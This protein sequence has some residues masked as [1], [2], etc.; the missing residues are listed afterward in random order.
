MENIIMKRNLH[1]TNFLF[2]FLFFYQSSV[3][4]LLSEGP[5]HPTFVTEENAGCLACQGSDWID[6]SNAMFPDSLYAS[7]QLNSYANC[8]MNACY[9][10]KS[11]K[12]ENFVFNIPATA[13]IAG[14]KVEVLRKASAANA[15]YDSIVQLLQSA[16]PVGNNK[17]YQGIPYPANASYITYGDTSDLWGFAWTPADINST[18]FGLF[19][20]P[21]NKSLNFDTAFVDHVAITVYYKMAAA[22]ALQ[23]ND[24]SK[25]FFDN[26]SCN[27][28]LFS[29]KSKAA[30]LTIYNIDGR[31]V[32]EKKYREQNVNDKINLDCLSAG[33]YFASCSG[34]NVRRLK[35]FIT[36]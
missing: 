15:V 6:Y 20:K 22:I 32:M 35:F 18:D 13:M 24:F 34:K 9:F 30:V 17:A 21:L 19:L 27:L 14:I 11:L 8:F 33:V 7:V 3:G 26:S 16:V 4:Q 1:V 2:L 25:M 31:K 5:Y 10:A 29:E 12:A 36:R 23:Q 28:F